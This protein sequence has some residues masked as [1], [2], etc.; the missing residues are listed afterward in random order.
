MVINEYG[1]QLS[2]DTQELKT[3]FGKKIKVTTEI[4]FNNDG[5]VVV[6]SAE[7]RRVVKRY[8]AVELSQININ[9]LGNYLAIKLL[10]VYVELGINVLGL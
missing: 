9:E 4:Y 5:M 3:L 1:V 10:P 7:D 8:T 2:K 6:L